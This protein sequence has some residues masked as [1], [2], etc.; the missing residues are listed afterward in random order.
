MAKRFQ[1]FFSAIEDAYP[2]IGLDLVATG[3]LHDESSKSHTINRFFTRSATSAHDAN[4]IVIN[5][6]NNNALDEKETQKKTK[7][8]LIFAKQVSPSNTPTP[9]TVSN[10]SPS[11]S[12][13]SMSFSEQQDQEM[14]EEQ[15]TEQ[16]DAAKTW[17]CD[18]CNKTILLSEVDEH[19]DYHFALEISQQDRVPPSS[20]NTSSSSS[21]SSA[22][23]RKL[24]NT[25]NNRDKKDDKKQK[26]SMFFQ[27]RS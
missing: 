5:N 1:H 20:A 21:S 26:L 9:A 16:E 3:L 12:I 7:N 11:I 8:M 24:N 22:K 6:N 10:S 25:K 13:S 17:S 23:K 14:K 27:P 18:K 15:G 4:G 19:T 2:C